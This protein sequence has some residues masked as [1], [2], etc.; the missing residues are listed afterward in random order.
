MT[1]VI[2]RLNEIHDEI[3][4]LKRVYTDNPK[5]CRLMMQYEEAIAHVSGFNLEELGRV[6][7]AFESKLESL[8][9]DLHTNFETERRMV[10]DN[11][12]QTD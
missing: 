10:V 12:P 2:I 8:Y 3:D 6:A 4:L 9:I 1:D 11:M 5:P 7:E